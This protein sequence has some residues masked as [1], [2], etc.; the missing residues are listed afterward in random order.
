M[1]TAATWKRLTERVVP[2]GEVEGYQITI[3]LT[4]LRIAR[5]QESCSVLLVPSPR[6]CPSRHAETLAA[7]L[8]FSLARGWPSNIHSHVVSVS[9]IQ[10]DVGHTPHTM[11]HACGCGRVAPSNHSF[12]VNLRF[13]PREGGR[14]GK[15]W[16]RVWLTAYRFLSHRPFYSSRCCCFSLVCRSHR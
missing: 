12:K 8:L 7:P 10:G 15:I 4:E 14:G 11:F 5:R 2:A 9:S 3:L 6:H 1:N 13:E 16:H